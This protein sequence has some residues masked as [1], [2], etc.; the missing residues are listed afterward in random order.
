MT[1]GINPVAPADSVRR[2]LPEERPESPFTP[3]LKT[4]MPWLFAMLDGMNHFRPEATNGTEEP[5]LEDEPELD[6]P[7][8]IDRLLHAIMGRFTLGVSPAAVALAYADW[9]A[10]LAQSPGKQQRLVEKAMRKATRL[11]LHALRTAVE[12]GQPPC[13]DPLPQDRRFRDPSWRRWPYNLIYQN[14]LL[15]QQWWHNATTGVRGVSAH[16]EDVVTFVTRQLLDVIAPSNFLST[17][18]ELQQA[19]LQEGGRNLWR[20]AVNAAEDWER[21]IAGKPPVGS[22]TLRIGTDVATTPGKVVH[23]NRLIELIQYEPTT[24][25]V[26]AEPIL[27]VPAWIMK[28]YILDLSPANSLVRFLVDQ[29]HTVFMISWRNP[30]EEDRDLGM[31]EYR[32]LGIDAALDAVSAIVPDR[33][34]NAVG[35]C[36]GGTLLS[37]A[38]AALARDGDKRLNSV[39]L[40]AA[41]ADFTEPGELSLFID[42]SELAYLED[43]MWD[44]GYLDTKQ[45]AGAFQLLRSN[46]LIW[47]HLQRNY[48]LGQRDPMSD[49]MAW[50]ADATRMPYR[51][52]SEYLRT[53]FLNNDLAEGRYQVDERPV[54]LTDIRAP[55]FAVGTEGDHV[56][57]WRSVYKIRLL[58]D[59]DVTFLLT[60]GG[61]NAGIVSEPGHPR[62][63]FRMSHQT[64]ESRYVDPDTWLM[65]TDAQEGSWWPAWEAWL[66]DRSTGMAAPPEMGAPDG[67]YPP[68]YAA[69]GEYVMRR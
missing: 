6:G 59:A 29:G 18:P 43:I 3:D 14:F 28:Y 49:L 36:L 38:A 44:Q 16:H 11:W 10:H 35:Y 67:N 22:D 66:T 53:L 58:T 39:T 65:A 2:R 8:S 62:R 41:Q 5:A 32:R 19:T 54:A 1:D 68:L 52:H 45:M 27:I 69:P 46:D 63:H 47:S 7:A 12:P 57:P 61:H 56:A 13:I 20:G 34:V 42:H 15:T 55:I 48:L 26:H 25:K 9:A 17:N 33:P 50:N 23:R 64:A 30:V 37:I 24:D 31:D 60:K 51:M 40:L 4:A 21:Q